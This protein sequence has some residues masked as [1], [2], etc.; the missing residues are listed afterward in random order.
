MKKPIWKHDC[1]KCRFIRTDTYN[2]KYDN[3]SDFYLCDDSMIIRHSDDPS[4]YGSFRLGTPEYLFIA[5]GLK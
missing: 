4:D 2:K 3:L 5:W 1:K